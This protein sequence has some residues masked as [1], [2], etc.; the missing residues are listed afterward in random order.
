[1]KPILLRQRLATLMR[2]LWMLALHNP[3]NDHTLDTIYLQPSKDHKESLRM[4]LLEAQT[5]LLLLNQK[6]HGLLD[7]A[8]HPVQ[9]STA[10]RPIL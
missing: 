1:M 5:W 8:Q 3:H 9:H 4:F 10:T 6:S 2:F 7:Q